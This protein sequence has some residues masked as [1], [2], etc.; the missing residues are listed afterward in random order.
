[1]TVE[2]YGESGDI[3]YWK[4]C[5]INPERNKNPTEQLNVVYLQF[6]YRYIITRF[7]FSMKESAIFYR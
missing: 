7:L 5:D 4:K 2:K 6:K 3:F 1:M